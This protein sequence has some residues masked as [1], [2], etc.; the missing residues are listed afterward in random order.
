MKREQVF[1]Y[2]G[3]VVASQTGL[4]TEQRREKWEKETCR[5]LKTDV[6]GVEWEK[7][8]TV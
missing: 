4:A 6:T 8:E 3:C 2:W 1:V 5:E 7:I